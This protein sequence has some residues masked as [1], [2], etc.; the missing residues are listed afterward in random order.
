MCS[1]SSAEYL[2]GSL[3]LTWAL[4]SAQAIETCAVVWKQQQSVPG[5][6]VTAERRGHLIE[7]A[8]QIAFLPLPIDIATHMFLIWMFS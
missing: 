3:S 2:S 7:T 8:K 1:S 6:V 4:Q 5:D